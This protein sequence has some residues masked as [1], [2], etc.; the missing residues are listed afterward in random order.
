MLKLSLFLNFKIKC[1]PER[2]EGSIAILINRFLTTF[3]KAGGMTIFDNFLLNFA[4]SLFLVSCTYK[5]TK[6]HINRLGFLNV[7]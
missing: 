1:H 4:I 2:S 6:P 3:L 7:I 5:K